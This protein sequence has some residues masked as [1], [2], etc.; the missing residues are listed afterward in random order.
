MLVGLGLFLGLALPYVWY[1][2]KQVR[3]EFA[4]LQWQVPTR[5]YARPL[6]LKSGCG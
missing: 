1:L 3:N 2:D 5:V 4:Q 6:L